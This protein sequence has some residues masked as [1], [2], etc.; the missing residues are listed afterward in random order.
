MDGQTALAQ[1]V[2]SAA[3]RFTPVAGFIAA[4]FSGLDLQ[5][6]SNWA[7]IAAN[8]AAAT[9]AITQIVLLIRKTRREKKA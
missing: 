2:A 1:D 6:L 3:K 7:S 8:V 4:K 5:A 9:Y